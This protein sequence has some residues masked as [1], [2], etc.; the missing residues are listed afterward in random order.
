MEGTNEELKKDLAGKDASSWDADACGLLFRGVDCCFNSC[1][2]TSDHYHCQVCGIISTE[3]AQAIAHVR[4]SPACRKDPTVNYSSPTVGMGADPTN[5]LYNAI[6]NRFPGQNSFSSSGFSGYSQL[7]SFQWHP[8]MSDKVAICSAQLSPCCSSNG[9]TFVPV[10]SQL[11]SPISD[12][13]SKVTPIRDLVSLPAKSAGSAMDSQAWFAAYNTPQMQKAAYKYPD[14]SPAPQINY[15]LLDPADQKNQDMGESNTSMTSNYCGKSDLSGKG[16]ELKDSYCAYSSQQIPGIISEDALFSLQLQEEN[17]KET[18]VPQMLLENSVQGK[19]SSHVNTGAATRVETNFTQEHFDQYMPSCSAYTHPGNQESQGRPAEL[20][21]QLSSAASDSDESDIIVED[22]G[23]DLGSQMTESEIFIE[24]IK[25]SLLQGVVS[26]EENSINRCAAAIRNE[27][28]AGLDHSIPLKESKE[29]S[30]VEDTKLQSESHL[31]NCM[32]PYHTILKCVIC[33]KSA[34]DSNSGS[35]FVQMNNQMPLTTSSH[36]PV[37][38]KL[39]EVVSIEVTDFLDVNGKLLCQS[40]FN[41]VDTVDTLES[42][43]E[44]L[45][46]DIAALMKSGP[47]PQVVA[48][49]PINLM[50]P[51]EGSIMNI[52]SRVKDPSVAACVQEL[53]QDSIVGN[54][55]VAR[56]VSL[57]EQSNQQ[58]TMNNNEQKEYLLLSGRALSLANSIN[59]V[60]LSLG[61]HHASQLMHGGDNTTHTIGNEESTKPSKIPSLLYQVSSDSLSTMKDRESINSQI[62]TYTLSD[63]NATLEGSKELSEFQQVGGTVEAYG[64]ASYGEKNL[65]SSTNC[66]EDIFR[67]CDKDEGRKGKQPKDILEK[68]ENCLPLNLP[69]NV[70]QAEEQSPHSLDCLNKNCHE[71][72]RSDKKI[73]ENIQRQKNIDQQLSIACDVCD[74]LFV[75]IQHLNSHLSSYSQS[76][77]SLCELCGQL[78]H[79]QAQLDDHMFLVHFIYQKHCE[80]CAIKFSHPCVY[81]THLRDH[82]GEKSTSSSQKVVMSNKRGAQGNSRSYSSPFVCYKC[83]KT[84]QLRSHLE[85][86]I[87]TT[88]ILKKALSKCDQCDRTFIKPSDLEAH[89]R[90]HSNDKKFECKFCGRR[91]KSLGNLNHH[92]KSHDTKKP[93]TCEVCSQGFTRKDFYETHINSHKDSKPYK[94]DKCQKGF[95][96]KSYLQVH[97]KWHLDKIKKVTCPICKKTFSQRLNVHMRSHTGERPHPCEKCPKKFITGSALR[98]HMKRIH[99]PN[100]SEDC[101]YS[102]ADG[103]D[104]ELP[105]LDESTSLS[106]SA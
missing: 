60:S 26:E 69:T 22:T 99:Q 9:G 83:S 75:S 47:K 58:K 45:K 18:E 2:Y 3:A 82:S 65:R 54:P 48:K 93:F 64:G 98:K 36:T 33:G 79:N 8:S 95:L 53:F 81:Q 7:D 86:H 43:L 106:C 66:K 88:H 94:C 68:E 38:T 87:K 28:I 73:Q 100:F 30:T 92:A 41:L 34:S 25:C 105:E 77:S 24:D 96:S 63:V 55:S 91:Y 57:Q 51:D 89:K 37:L 40:C 13:Y 27:D 101:V 44:S 84:F 5:S 71:I 39:N 76:D 97:L 10:E 67:Q 104:A 6:Y 21:N 49:L 61:Q 35:V 12:L 32:T 11:C 74:N 56:P 103:S 80:V 42:K 29:P 46:Q 15:I 4:S 17:F 78:N 19:T 14:Q 85:H 70:R 50:D 23:D 31:K 1:T 90:S 52:H 16:L 62:E 59:K 20:S 102:T 72:L